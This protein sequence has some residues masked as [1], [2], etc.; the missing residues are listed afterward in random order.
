[1]KVSTIAYLGLSALL[2]GFMQT[3]AKGVTIDPFNSVQTGNSQFV[4]DGD[5]TTSGI[6]GVTN[7]DTGLT[8]VLGEKRTI[9]VEKISPPNDDDPA[10]TVQLNIN[11][12][13]QKAAYSSTSGTSGHFNILWDGDFDGTG[14]NNYVDL[15]DAGASNSFLIKVTNN[16][17]GV[18]LNFDVTGNGGTLATYSQLV[19]P[20]TTGDVYFP[21]ASFTNSSVFQQ[22]E[23]IEL[24][25]SNEPGDLDFTFQFFSSATPPP[26]GVPFE[27]S[28]GLGMILGGGF[29]SLNTLRKKMKA[30]SNLL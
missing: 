21:F 12:I 23:S 6:G 15:T 2:L 24:Y 22:A 19:S 11:K 29:L 13:Q 5:S 7:P 9:S 26:V 30:S 8:G 14:S 1:M 4:Q 27:F 18:R 17:L 3:P 10:N 28:P 20:G 16:D 25:S